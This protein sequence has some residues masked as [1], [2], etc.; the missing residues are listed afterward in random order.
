MT[1]FK[2]SCLP[3]MVVLLLL[4]I[5]PAFSHPREPRKDCPPPTPKVPRKECKD[6]RPPTPKVPKKECKDCRPPTPK[7]PRKELS[8]PKQ[9][10]PPP[11]EPKQ[12]PPPP[13]E[14]KQDP[15]PPEEPKQDPPP[16][17]EE[18]KKDPPPPEEPKKDP[19]PPKTPKPEIDLPPEEPQ[20]PT[21]FHNRFEGH[22]SAV[23]A[24]GDSYTDTG[25]A[26]E[27]GSLTLTFKDTPESPYTNRLSNGRLVIDFITDS[28]G[29]PNIPPYQST[30]ANFTTGVN[31]AIAGATTVA[32]DIFSK[33]ARVFLWKGTPLGIMTEMD[34]YKKYQIEHLC[35]GLDKKQ[36][37]EKIKTVL[38]WVGEI[39]LND[40]TRAV[41]S[42]IPLQTIARSS[43][44]YTSE[45]IR[46]LIRNGAK[47]IVVQGLPPLGCLPMDISL[48]PISLRDRSGCSLII[49]SAVII[50]NQILQAKL[51]LYR[52]L[53]PDVTII[54]A[55]SWKA[56]YEIVNNP[57]KYKIQEVRKT[58]CGSSMKPE[59]MN[60]NMQSFC[61]SS[62][63]TVCSDPSQY[64][65]WDG[66]H[67]TETMNYHM[68]EQYI[69]HGCCQPPFDELM[70]KKPGQ[71]SA[72]KPDQKPA[73][74]PAPK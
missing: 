65:S 32:N 39:G 27:L 53:Y 40:F 1:R 37:E 29:L 58:C 18:P 11:E 61:G 8:P 49:N 24:F 23:I 7:V 63:A 71:K 54:Y 45:L 47:N 15:P 43:V 4:I 13:E 35:K 51:E 5:Y 66:I 12:D 73:Q 48:T 41:G 69:D 20:K 34:W 70:K 57:Q 38:F 42:K 52:K 17:Q 50:H 55:D 30:K 14:P 26:Q 16:P 72:P 6:C 22:F 36:C 74:K 62:G 60:F 68:T 31:L 44:T 10:P 46:T 9:D 3:L 64:V 33:L 56:Y 25:N 28:L 21:P 19:P 59:D 67:P 2:C